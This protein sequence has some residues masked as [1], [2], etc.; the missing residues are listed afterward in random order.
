MI[1][2]ELTNWKMKGYEYGNPELNPYYDQ[3][4]W[5]FVSKSYVTEEG[6]ETADNTAPLCRF[7]FTV[8]RGGR[9]HITIKNFYKRSGKGGID[10][11]AFSVELIVY[12]T[13]H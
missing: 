4:I 7:K 1:I 8:N 6:A 13:T 5:T 3:S 12:A 11:V 9:S 10:Y 2:V